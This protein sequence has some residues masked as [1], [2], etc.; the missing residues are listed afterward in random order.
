[1]LFSCAVS[2]VL[3]AS[4]SATFQTRLINEG[5]SPW[6]GEGERWVCWMIHLMVVVVGGDESPLVSGSGEG[7]GIG[8]K[9]L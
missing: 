8:G 2:W 5:S 6:R 4:S 1:M 9:L 3:T 7:L